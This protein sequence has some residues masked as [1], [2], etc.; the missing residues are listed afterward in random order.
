MWQKLGGQF[1]AEG[2]GKKK[3]RVILHEKLRRV[4]GE[5]QRQAK[6]PHPQT[7]LCLT[8]IILACTYSITTTTIS[9]TIQ[10][11]KHIIMRAVVSVVLVVVGEHIQEDLQ[12]LAIL[13]VGLLI[14]PF[15]HLHQPQA[16]HLHSDL[17]LGN[18]L[19]QDCSGNVLR[20]LCLQAVC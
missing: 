4:W 5:R 14:H 13:H 9:N 7:R 6:Q 16:L 8:L 2:T 3:M 20:L 19:Q 15:Q 11:K 10:S 18:Q 12:M 1:G 17:L